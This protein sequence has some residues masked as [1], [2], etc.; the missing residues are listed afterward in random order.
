VEGP[1]GASAGHAG[2]TPAT[3]GGGSGLLQQSQLLRLLSLGKGLR[4][5]RG[6]P[7]EGAHSKGARLYR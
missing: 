3:R 4:A 1:R 5:G 7:S 6:P 2:P